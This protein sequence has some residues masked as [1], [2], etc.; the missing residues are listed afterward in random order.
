MNTWVRTPPGSQNSWCGMSDILINEERKLT[1]KYR[2]KK[3][4]FGPRIFVE[5]QV[6][7]YYSTNSRQ[8]TVEHEPVFMWRKAHNDD[9]GNLTY[10]VHWD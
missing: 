1:G 3:T 7:T 5:E 9:L 8:E 6:R 2:L 4:W 10:F